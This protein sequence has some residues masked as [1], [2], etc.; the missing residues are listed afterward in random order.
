LQLAGIYQTIATGGLGST[1][2]NDGGIGQGGGDA[3]GNAPAA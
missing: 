1:G 2:V 3:G